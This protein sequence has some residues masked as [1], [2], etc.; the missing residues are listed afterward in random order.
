MSIN[1]RAIPRATWWGALIGSGINTLIWLV[2]T[3]V[4]GAIEIIPPSPTM[5]LNANGYAEILFFMP[6]IATI[7]GSLGAALVFWMLAR[8]SQRP[9]LYFQIVAF[10]ALALSFVSVS[11]AVTQTGQSIL[12]LMHICAAMPIVATLTL[13][14]PEGA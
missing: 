6:A 8:W 9:Q 5:P 12:G 11:A 4:W 2:A 3:Q 14:T 7:L 13:F 1:M 10:I